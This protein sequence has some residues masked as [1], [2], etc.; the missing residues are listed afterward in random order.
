M[1]SSVSGLIELT[2]PRILVMVLVTHALGFFLGAGGL[3]PVSVFLLSLLGTGL[4]CAGAAVLNHYL[5]RDA[6]ARMKR[7]RRRP[8]VS[9]EVSP[10]DALAFGIVLILAGTSLLVWK[11]NLI[12]GFLALLTA[13]LYVLVYTPLKRV[14]WLNTSIGSIP[15]AL[16]P[17]G[18]WSAATGELEMGGWLLFLILFLWQHPHFYAIAWMYR[19]DY[20]RGGFKMLPVVEPD[21]RSTFRQIVAF[22]LVLLPVSIVPTLLG[23]AGSVYLVGALV[24]GG[25]MLY[26]GL[27]LATTHAVRHARWVLRASVVYLPLL[28]VLI[29][30]D[31]TMR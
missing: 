10:S 1:N 20:A 4:T 17:L 30:A 15:G 22:S 26:P 23:M 21:G 3:S 7:T 9:G 14:T 25:L 19:E 2:K 5:E 8:L 18:G 31:A 13:F 27:C 12:T 24:L 6:D 29:V 16:P 11:V 28:L